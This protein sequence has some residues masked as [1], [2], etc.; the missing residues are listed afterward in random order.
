MRLPRLLTVLTLALACGGATAQVQPFT[1]GPAPPPVATSTSPTA[2]APVV[3]GP[4][5]TALPFD[6][7]PEGGRAFVP[8]AP[9]AP[10]AAPAQVRT[11]PVRVPP[12]T[13][14]AI[15][16]PV[17]EPSRLAATMRERLLVPLPRLRLE[18]E[19]DA[20]SWTVFLS[21]DEAASPAE[22]AIGFVNAVVVMP[23]A[24]ALRVRINGE[25]VLETPIDSSERVGTITTPVAPGILRAGPNVLRIEAVQRH[26]TDCTLQS[27]YE[28]WAEIDA[29]ATRLIFAGGGER[30]LL[31]LDDLPAIGVDGDGRTG[32]RIVA[33]AIA[34]P[35]AGNEVLRLVQ[36]IAVKGR[37][38]HPVVSVF[39]RMPTEAAGPGTLTVIVGTASEL[40]P[41]YSD[42]PAEASSRA[43][44]QILSDPA[45][46]GPVM[47]I[48]GPGWGDVASG[49]DA[50]VAT[51]DR[52]IGVSRA[53]LDTAAWMTPDPP[54]LFG[55][56]ALRFA[57]LGVA[58]QEFSGRRFTTRFSVALPS[59]FY[60]SAYGTARMVLDAA[61]TE[62]VLPGSHLDAYVNG[63]L[64]TTVPISARS[65]GIFRQ[66]PIEVPLTHFRPGVNTILIEVLID[67]VADQACLP[68]AT[69]VG[70]SRFVL[71]DTT[72]FEMPRFARIA[73]RP[74]LA[75]FA[76]ASFPYG[77]DPAPLALAL[78]R[79]DAPTFA[80]AATLLARMAINAGR[81]IRIDAA[82]PP[83]AVGDRNALFVGTIGQ[84]PAGI[85]GTL[86]IAEGAR[87]EWR[88]SIPQAVPAG[89]GGFGAVIE[90]FR[91][92]QAEGV[93]APLFEQ[94]EERTVEVFDRWRDRLSGSG[95]WRNTVDKFD[96]WLGR[97]FDLSFASLRLLPGADPAFEP[98]ERA[99]LVVAQSGSPGGTAT[100]TL[101]AAP[102]AA[103]LERSVGEITAE[104]V[105]SRISGKVVAYLPASNQLQ[106]VPVR[107]FD[108][109]ET[110]A[111][112][113]GN[114]R[115]IAANWLSANALPY[116][117]AL[118]GLCLFLGVAT[119]ALLARMGRKS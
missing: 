73:R 99:E 119:S 60:A 102:S 94:G 74:D 86:G 13:P 48:S 28:L 27:T 110:T 45:G 9:T 52:P 23:E 69:I 79:Y 81:V 18:G 108:F 118:F 29:A 97:T 63:S 111:F 89:D 105:W 30:R 16:P 38:P 50:V 17:P 32:I 8:P 71:F 15:A 103:Q 56:E 53:A 54:I 3:R 91:G 26:R 12:L 44:A 24:S 113:L 84:M 64:A 85:L 4:S 109:V 116:A 5:A 80:A 43:V 10:A 41:V 62:E 67:T 19:I 82:V 83:T 21:A 95:G 66:F 7:T 117:L 37:Y 39:E 68:G 55:G 61:F 14:P 78:G 34:Q 87:T 25:P 35:R 58:T 88:E 33:P 70:T 31:G 57:D 100:W 90:R 107:S 76:G 51:A 93:D 36:A 11:P 49:V 101:V 115:L 59:D 65:G 77:R 106:A 114:F 20:R 46:D 75:A 98:T 72:V 1:V 96:A 22:F 40:L 92:S 42:L 112:S 2:V 47:L 104:D 6:L